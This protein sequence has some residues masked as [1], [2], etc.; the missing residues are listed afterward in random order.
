MKALQFGSLGLTVGMILYVAFFG[1][2]GTFGVT[3]FLLVLG[4]TCGIHM[5]VAVAE[6]QIE[7]QIRGERIKQL[8]T[9]V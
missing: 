1:S 2:V 4:A 5:T 9:R 3:S 7:K 6:T 8:L